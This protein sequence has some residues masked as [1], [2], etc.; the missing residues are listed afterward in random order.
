MNSQPSSSSTRS[1][2]LDGGGA[3]ATTILVLSRPGTGSP[4]A[5]LA[6]A[7]SRIAATTAGAPHISV[8]PCASIRRSSSSPSILRTTTCGMPIA[9]TA[10]GMPQPLQWNIGSVC[11]YTSRSVTV[12]CQPKIAAF[13]QQLRWVSCTPLGRAVV[14]LV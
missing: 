1:I 6:D 4:V 3:P 7:A 8:T 11:M 2:V 5:R 10:Y 9:V 13:S 12:V 14:P